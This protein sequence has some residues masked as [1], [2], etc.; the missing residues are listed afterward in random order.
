[1]GCFE[2]STVAFM[3]LERSNVEF[4]IW[5]KKVDKSLFEHNG[6]TVPEWAC[7]MWELKRLYGD[8][9]SRKDVRSRASVTFKGITYEAWVTTAPHGRSSPAFRLW[10][11][12]PLSYELKSAFAMSYMRSLEGSLQSSSDPEQQI[13]FWEFLDIEFDS[14]NHTFRFV[15]YYTVQPS[16]PNLFKR[17]VGSPALRRIEDEVQDKEE[18]RIH[19]Q[20]W[21]ARSELEYE[22]GATNVV[23]MLY[24]SKTKLVYLGEAENLVKRLLQPHN[25]IPEW[26]FFR[27]N[28]LPA[29]LAPYRIAL[30]RM[31][32]RDFAAILKNKRE[33]PWQDLAGCCLAN[34]KIDR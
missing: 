14:E 3:K 25:S 34:D 4:A 6:T 1:M 29:V 30:E 32:I 24:D 16:F 15:A 21:K 27:Y 13:S 7:R 31:I 19:K 22:L 23:Y 2:V 26:D 9:T 10:Y 12:K 33:I 17:L 11:D 18:S 8:I 5:R 20:D 28:V